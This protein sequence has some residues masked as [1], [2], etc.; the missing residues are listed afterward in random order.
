MAYK[1]QG[2]PPGYRPS[3]VELKKYLAEW[4]K[5]KDYVEHE[6]ALGLIFRDDPRFSV[7][8]DLRVVLIK[9]TV[10]NKFYSTNIFKIEPI[11]RKITRIKNFDARLAKGDDQLIDEIASAG[12]KRHYSFATKYCSHHHPSLYPIYD[13]FVGEVLY[14]LHKRHGNPDVFHFRKR[15]DLKD[16]PTFRQAIDDF[17]SAYNLTSSSYKDIDRYLWQLGKEH[18]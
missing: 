16:Y 14:E 13:K 4:D 9:C 10:L 12:K 2:L 3:A 15:D 1:K 11:A 5:L 18:Y 6:K 7:N 17:R 8:T